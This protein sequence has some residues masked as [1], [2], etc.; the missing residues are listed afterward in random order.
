MQFS[1]NLPSVSS[2]YY[3]RGTRLNKAPPICLYAYTHIEVIL[4]V[5]HFTC[6]NRI[7]MKAFP[8]ILPNRKRISQKAFMVSQR[9]AIS[10]SDR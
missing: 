9:P 8:T 4:T 6:S 7:K 10:K 1:G 5:S 2:F 3:F